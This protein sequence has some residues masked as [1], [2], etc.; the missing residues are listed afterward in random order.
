M[1]SLLTDD[2]I[3]DFIDWTLD[4]FRHFGTR[5]VAYSWVD[6]T[7]VTINLDEGL[8]WMFHHAVGHTTF[9]RHRLQLTELEYNL[10]DEE[11]RRQRLIHRELIQLIADQET[12]LCGVPVHQYLYD[13]LEYAERIGSTHPYERQ[14]VIDAARKA[15]SASLPFREYKV[16][17]KEM[18]HSMCA[19]ASHEPIGEN[20]ASKVETPCEHQPDYS[21]LHIEHDG[22]GAYIDV[23][24]KHC[25][26][27]GCLYKVPNDDDINW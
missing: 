21:T 5:P 27:S 22:D 19:K 4:H 24:C 20:S 9:E 10:S 6:D 15:H 14:S 25:G 11:G 26:R 2:V 8:V 23:N 7:G 17:L 13:A 12:G 3:L 16:V 18:V 1:T